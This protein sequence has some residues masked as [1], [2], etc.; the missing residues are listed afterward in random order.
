MISRLERPSLVRRAT[1][2][3]VRGSK[4][5]RT[6]TMRLGPTADACSAADGDIMSGRR[7][8]VG[9]TLFV[10]AI[11]VACG[12]SGD[13]G[14]HTGTELASTPDLSDVNRPLTS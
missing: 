12:S 8:L 4:T 13:S 10:L 7:W 11:A 9:A 14:A 6:M 2:G 1:Q 3:R 5:I